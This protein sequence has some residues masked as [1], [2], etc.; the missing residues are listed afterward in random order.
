MDNLC[1]V[2]T[3]HYLFN[4]HRKK[5]AIFKRS[6]E[7]NVYAGAHIKKEKYHCVAKKNKSVGE[8]RVAAGE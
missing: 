7:E 1:S 2:Y 4:D 8:A 5:K 3:K 6:N